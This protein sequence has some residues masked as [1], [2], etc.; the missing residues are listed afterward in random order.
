VI[1]K[2][3][4]ALIDMKRFHKKYPFLNTGNIKLYS[5]IT[6]YNQSFLITTL[7]Y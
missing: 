1:T 2:C 3:A 6:F 4:G 7:I 5:G